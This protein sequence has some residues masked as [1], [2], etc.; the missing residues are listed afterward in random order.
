MT[1]QPVK[2]IITTYIL[3]NIS[4]S[5]DNQIMKSGELIEYKTRNF[6]LKNLS[7]NVVENYFENL[8]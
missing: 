3:P 6:F 7:Q 1:S 4:R 2:Q 5:K 8:F